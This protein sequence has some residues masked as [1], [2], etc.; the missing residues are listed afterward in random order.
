MVALAFAGALAAGGVL[1]QA[2]RRRRR[3]LAPAS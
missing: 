2:L 1:S 3:K